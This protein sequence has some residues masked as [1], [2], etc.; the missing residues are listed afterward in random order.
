VGDPTLYY[1]NE[2]F[3]GEDTVQPL[4]QAV[5]DAATAIADPVLSAMGIELV[6]VEFEKKGTE[7]FLTFYIDKPGGIT[8]DDCEA[9][10]QALDEP[11][12]NAPDVAGKHDHLIVSS[13]GLDRPLKTDRDFLRKLQS[14]IEVK[15]QEP[16]GGATMVV[17]LLVSVG[18][19]HIVVETAK[20][21]VEIEKNNIAL[22]RPAIDM[23]WRNEP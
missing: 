12:D 20:K 7:W 16:K 18:D 2:Q 21:R 3:I 14:K 6:E 22:A 15:L 1:C 13:P 8:L 9:A 4:N 19:D 10:S 11:L 17:G 5:V 23:T